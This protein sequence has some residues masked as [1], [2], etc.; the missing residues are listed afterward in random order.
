MN[1]HF[2]EYLVQAYKLQLTDDTQ[3][4]EIT[5]LSVLKKYL[6][7]WPKFCTRY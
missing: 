6:D 2:Q 4:K 7:Y 1:T 3:L 5:Y